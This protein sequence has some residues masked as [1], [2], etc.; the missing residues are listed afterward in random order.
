MTSINDNFST[1][2]LGYGIRR[3]KMTT[4]TDDYSIGHTMVEA[5]RASRVGDDAFNVGLV[6]TTRA[7]HGLSHDDRMLRT[8]T[9][10]I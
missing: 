6:H 3:E 4:E 5:M 1:A 2:P 7:Q 10:C 9:W 8:H